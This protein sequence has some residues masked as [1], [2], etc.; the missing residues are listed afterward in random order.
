MEEQIYTE[1]LLGYLSKFGIQG[2]DVTVTWM[3]DTYMT[4]QGNFIASYLGYTYSQV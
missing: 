4:V 2:D 3:A 1:F